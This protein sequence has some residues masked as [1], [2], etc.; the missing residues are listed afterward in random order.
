[1]SILEDPLNTLV[2]MSTGERSHHCGTGFN[3]NF[4]DCVKA[5]LV[6]DLASSTTSGF[7]CLSH[8][9]RFSRISLN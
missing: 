7:G 2:S 4:G 3:G 6:L 8:V 1:M 5:Y 9:S